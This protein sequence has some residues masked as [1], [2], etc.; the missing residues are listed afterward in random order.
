MWP[1][2]SPRADD[3]QLSTGNIGDLPA[4]RSKPQTDPAL[5]KAAKEVLEQPGGA[6]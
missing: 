4:F 5:A 2:L 6:R 1:E 3:A